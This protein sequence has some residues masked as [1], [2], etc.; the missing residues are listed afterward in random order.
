MPSRHHLY[1]MYSAS[2]SEE[3]E[4][5]IE[6]DPYEHI[7]WINQQEV[8]FFNDIAYGPFLTFHY[9]YPKTTAWNQPQNI[10]LRLLL[11]K[12]LDQNTL[13]RICPKK[14]FINNGFATLDVVGKGHMHLTND[15]IKTLFL[16]AERWCRIHET[17]CVEWV[18]FC[19]V[20]FS[21]I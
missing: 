4:E 11:H 15:D 9:R 1:H 2:E 14:Y 17:N 6:Y 10:R 19:I 20:Q 8:D 3:E 7:S 13:D 5:E 12:Y 21:C 18:V 16:F